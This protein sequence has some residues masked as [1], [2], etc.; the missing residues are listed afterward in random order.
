MAVT[1][2]NMKKSV[3]LILMGILVYMTCFWRLDGSR[4]WRDEASTAN[5]ARA[6]VQNNSWVP[7]VWDGQQ[8]MVHGADGHDFDENF[9]PMMQSW[10]QFYV[11]AL[12]FK[13]FGVSTFT[14][15]LLFAL[16]S[17]MAA[18][19]MYFT[20]F[21][22]NLSADKTHSCMHTLSYGTS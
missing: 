11:C 2:H 18:I 4:L 21:F 12:A 1:S 6:M 15:R 16:F 8:L 20:P 19:V 17:A 7:K 5:W 22:L 3:V 10:G 14:A 13:L 9:I